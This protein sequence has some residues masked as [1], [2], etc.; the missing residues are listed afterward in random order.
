MLIPSKRP[1][2][3][4]RATASPT[5]PR[6]VE[7]GAADRQTVRV[8]FIPVG[9]DAVLIEVSGPEEALALATWAR[10]A[11]LPVGEIVPAAATV[12][13]DDVADAADL[14]RRLG[15]W[16]PA[17]STP[18]GPL[19]EIPVDYDG[20]D[21]ADVAERWGTDVDGVVARHGSVE[22]VAAFCGFAPGFSYLAGLPDELAVPRLDTP[23]TRVPSGAVG[24]A[25]AWCAVYP[26]ESPGGWRLIGRT[27][28]SLWDARRE[29]PALLPPGTRVRFV[30]A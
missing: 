6:R 12:L 26:S 15:A 5:P 11:R 24:L 8:E 21:L 30:P 29:Q 18:R 1:S 20:D 13:L 14:E 27:D 9:R 16:S 7:P 17:T 25:G 28:A 23:R 2:P 19:V 4:F 3:F 22:F 10:G